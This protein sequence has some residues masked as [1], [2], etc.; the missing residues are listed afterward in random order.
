MENREDYVNNGLKQLFKIWFQRAVLCY[1]VIFIA[2][3][4]IDYINTPE[5]FQY[6]MILRTSTVLILFLLVFLARKNFHRGILFH[7]LLAYTGIITTA[8]AVALMA[9]RSGGELYPLY[10]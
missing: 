1:A 3:G 8:V 5:N 10:S 4:F 7:R 6:F 2:F 9:S